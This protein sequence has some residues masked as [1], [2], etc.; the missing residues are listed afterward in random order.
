MFKLDGSKTY[1][2]AGLLGLVTAGK[3]LGFVPA[4]LA[5]LLTNMLIGTGMATLKHAISKVEF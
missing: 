1:I 3:F 4:P 2:V 5:D